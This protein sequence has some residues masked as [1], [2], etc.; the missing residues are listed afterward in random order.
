[1]GYQMRKI[2]RHSCDVFVF[3]VFVA[4]QYEL[5]VCGEDLV[6]IATAGDKKSWKE[7]IANGADV[8][9]DKGGFALSMA[10]NERQ[11]RECRGIYFAWC[12]TLML[13]SP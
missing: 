8:K 13:G 12:Q 10:A 9:G 5:R 7:L 4:F 2:L 11:I 3:C 1:M 6:S